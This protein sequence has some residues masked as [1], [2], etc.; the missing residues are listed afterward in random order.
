M[1]LR[2]RIK[3]NWNFKLLIISIALIVMF[4]GCNMSGI[5]EGQGRVDLAIQS[6]APAG[7]SASPSRA[8]SS[9]MEIPVTDSLGTQIGTIKLTEALV[10]L[11]EIELE[12]AEAEA[13]TLEEIEQNSEIEFEGPYIV[14]LLTDTITP[15][16]DSV[17]LLPGNYDEIELDLDSIGGEEEDTDGNQLV[18]PSHPLF[19]NSIYLNGSYTG[20]TAGGDVT[21]IPFTYEYDLD[22]EFELTGSSDTS[23]GFFIDEG[24]VNNII[25]AFR[26][27]RWFDFSNSETNSDNYDFSSLVVS[28][29]GSEPFILLDK[30][31]EGANKNLREVIEKNIEESADYGEDLD[32]DGE[33]D[34]EEDDDPDSEDE[35]DD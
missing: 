25:I 17:D 20:A 8:I 13:D 34:S 19:G 27:V 26:L 32:D 1:L 16:L 12:L 7:S 18:D 2:S 29:S 14:N 21:D 9:N 15:S 3:N 5:P 22:K 4:T 23:E 30:T 24:A 33:L 10:A 28:T 31:A 11:K 6:T 35:D